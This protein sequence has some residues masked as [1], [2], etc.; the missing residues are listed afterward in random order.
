MV[1]I[2]AHS[3]PCGP[4]EYF[5]DAS[6]IWSYVWLLSCHIWHFAKITC[7]VIRLRVQFPDFVIKIICL[8]YAS[9]FMSQVFN[10]YYMFIEIKVERPEAYV[11][12]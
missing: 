1:I 3:P 9:E 4:F 2:W 7:Q 11:H 10:D 12:I 6:T 5:I 8:N